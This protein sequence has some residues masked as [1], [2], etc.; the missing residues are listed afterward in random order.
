M[1]S[2]YAKFTAQPPAWHAWNSHF[3]FVRI[4]KLEIEKKLKTKEITITE[5]RQNW[6]EEKKP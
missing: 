5:T 3:A 1:T 2:D 6:N 4:L